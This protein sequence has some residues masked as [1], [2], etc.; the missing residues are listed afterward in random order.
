MTSWNLINT[1]SGNGLSPIRRQAITWTNADSFL[2]FNWTF[3]N[4]FQ[5]SFIQNSNN[6]N[7][8]NVVENIACNKWRPFCSGLTDFQNQALW[9]AVKQY[10]IL[11]CTTPHCFFWILH[12]NKYLDLSQL[13]L[14]SSSV[15][16]EV[17]V[18]LT[19]S[20]DTSRWARDGESYWGRHE[21]SWF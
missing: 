2:I 7:Q 3:R 10:Y 14:R 11:S 13:P 18:W 16:I 20:T 19:L 15:A 4:T 5:W 6:F 9:I 8:Q 21:C 17:I 12:S 1:A